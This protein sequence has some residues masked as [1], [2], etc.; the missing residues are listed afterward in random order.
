M[1]LTYILWWGKNEGILV[2][3]EVP[4]EILWLLC[5][6][7]HANHPSQAA[8]AQRKGEKRKGMQRLTQL[9]II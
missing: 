8:E 9:H 1:L 4:G 2:E 5:A 6:K 7:V 3:L